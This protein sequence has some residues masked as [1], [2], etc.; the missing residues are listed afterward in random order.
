MMIF[1]MGRHLQGVLLNHKV[2]YRASGRK[3]NERPSDILV[4]AAQRDTVMP[5]SGRPYWGDE[6]EAQLLKSVEKR[7]PMMFQIRMRQRETDQGTEIGI[8]VFYQRVPANSGCNSGRRAEA[9]FHS[10]A[11]DTLVNAQLVNRIVEVRVSRRCVETK[12]KNNLGWVYSGAEAEAVLWKEHQASK[13]FKVPTSYGVSSTDRHPGGVCAKFF[14]NQSPSE[15]APRPF[16]NACASAIGLC[17]RIR[18]RSDG[19]IE[20]H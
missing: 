18:R 11:K 14:F 20:P 13:G 17:Q 12:V 6:T 8:P 7:K 10:A 15:E 2:E 1:H 5:T 4:T 19:S 16:N 9:S 3:A